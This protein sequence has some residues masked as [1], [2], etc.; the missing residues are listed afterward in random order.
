MKEK[1]CFSNNTGT[2][3]IG[4]GVEGW[5]EEGEGRGGG[6]GGDWVGTRLVK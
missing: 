3:K 2:T 5:G 1:K 6:K 4:G